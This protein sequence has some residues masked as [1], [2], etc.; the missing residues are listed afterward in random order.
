MNTANPEKGPSSSQIDP[1]E[2]ITTEASAIDYDRVPKLA[3]DHGNGILDVLR[4]ILYPPPERRIKKIDTIAFVNSF[5]QATGFKELDGDLVVIEDPVGLIRTLEDGSEETYMEKMAKERSKGK[6]EAVSY[7]LG[8]VGKHTFVGIV[9]NWEFMGGTSG[10]VAGEKI[11]R[12]AQLAAT[13]NMPIIMVVPSGG[14]RQQEGAAALREMLRTTFTLNQFKKETNQP[15][16]AVLV[17]NTWGGLMASAIPMADVVIGMAD[18]DCGFAGPGVIEAFE[19][20]RPPDGAQSVENISQTNRNV[21]VILN[22]QAELLEYLERTLE[23]ANKINQP[24]GKPKRLR[25]VSGI[26]Y[27]YPFP[28]HLPWRPKRVLRSHPRTAISSPIELAEPKTVWDQHQVL[29]SDPRRPDPLYILQNGFDGFVPIFSG[30]IEKGQQ[31]KQLKYPA[32]VAAIAY[33]DN[34]RLRTRLTAMVIGNQ[35]SYLQLSDGKIMKE[36]ANPTAWDFRYQLRM[37]EFAERLRL[38]IISFVDT[39]GARPKLEDDSAAQY[40]AIANCLKAQSEYPFFTSGYLIGVGGS[41]GALATYFTGDYAAMLSGAQEFVAEPRSAAAILYKKPTP[42]DIIRTAEGM[43]PTVPFLFSRG[44]IDRIIWEP[45]GGA[46]NHPLETVRAIREDIT[47]TW[48]A[49]NN[50]TPEE[51]LKR[52]EQRIRNLRPIPIGHLDGRAE[53]QR[54]FLK[55]LLGK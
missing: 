18:T 35:P 15:L 34:R 33:I 45:E 16:I 1:I 51:I 3:E 4:R 25:E 40:E 11:A 24:P 7:G 17:G 44:L 2:A 10:V 36:P 49:V 52:R 22:T 42:Q 9:F 50:L 26:Y 6:K 19:G 55:K 32:I 5:R 28:N 20:K 23:I 8:E 12:A 47:L 13:N 21:P 31:G 43:Q 54:P 27:G 14:Q 46:Q 29:S 37:I 30:R 41:G 38:P 39:F 53:E 48:L